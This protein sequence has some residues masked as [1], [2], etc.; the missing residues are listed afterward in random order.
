MSKTISKNIMN[1]D[2]K[3][4]MMLLLAMVVI[5]GLVMFMNC[6]SQQEYLKSS[7]DPNEGNDYFLKIRVE[8]WAVTQPSLQD[9]S[10]EF[11]KQNQ[12]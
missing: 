4:L 10:Y 3:D 2:N 6:G 1:A 11:K 12:T 9:E 8:R 7:S 5:L